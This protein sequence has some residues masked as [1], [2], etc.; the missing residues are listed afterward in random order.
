METLKDKYCGEDKNKQVPKILVG[1]F[2]AVGGA[3]SVIANTPID[4]IKTRMQGFEAAKY[5]STL[6]CFRKIWTREGPL[7]FYRGTVPR[8]LTACMDVA[9]TF[10]VY[11]SFIDLLNFLGA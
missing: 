2:G 8:L 9:I 10:M 3:A 6:D 1:L 7:A 4:V 11:D 5:S